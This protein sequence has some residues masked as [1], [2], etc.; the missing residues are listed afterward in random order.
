MPTY[1]KLK[2]CVNNLIRNNLERIQLYY[3]IS[4]QYQC[5]LTNPGLNEMNFTF[6]N[7]LFLLCF[8]LSA[9]RSSAQCVIQPTINFVN[10]SFEGTPGPGLTPSPWTECMPG[11]TPDT[12]PGSWG[13][14]LPPTNGSTYIGLVH[15]PSASWQEGASEQLGSPFLAG[16]SYTFTVDLANSSSTGGGIDPGCAECQIWGGF[17]DCDQNTLLW[18]SGNITPY[19]TWQT[20]TVTFTPTQNFTYCMFQVHGLGCSAQPYILVDNVSAV[21]PSNV[22]ATAAVINNDNCAND[23]TGKGI[24][25]TVGVNPPYTY[26]WSSPFGVDSTLNNVPA[27]SYTV[28]V[29]DAHTCTATASLTITQPLAITLTPDIIQPG[30]SAS[31]GSA[32]MSYAGGTEPFSFIWSNGPTTQ[33]DPNL[34]AGTY[35]ITAT[36][37]NGCKATG[38]VAIV[39]A[40]P[41]TLAANITNATCAASDGSIATTVSGGNAPYTYQWSTAPVQTTPT[42]TGLA[43]NS[44]SLT[45]TDAITCSITAIF[46][47]SQPPPG[48]T[49]SLLVTDIPCFGQGTGGINTNSS[50]GS[51]PYSYVWSNGSTSANVNNLAAGPYQVTINDQTGCGFILDTTITQPDS[52]LFATVTETDIKCN[53][54]NTGTAT[55]VAVGGTRGYTYAWNS[56]PVQTNQVA[57]NLPQNQ[58][59]V[60]VTDANQCTFTATTTV[61]QPAVL[62]ISETH[63]DVLCY[64]AS[65]GS[66]TATANGGVQPYSYHWNTA[67][68]DTG[69]TAPNLPSATYN[70]I[71]TDANLCTATTSSVI[72]QPVSPLAV[73]D[74]LIQPICFGQTPATASATAS[75]GTPGAG[76]SYLWNTSPPQTTQVISNIPAGTYTIVVTDANACTVSDSIVVTTPTALVLNPVVVNVLCFG[77]N[78]GSIATNASG[79]YG[80][81]TYLWSTAPVQTTSTATQLIAGNYNVTVTDMHGCT[82]SAANVVTQ[83]AAPLT[84][85]TDSTNV[86]CFGANTGAA[87]VTA[88]GGTTA[89][90]YAWNT[91]PQQNTAA[92]ISLIAGNYKVTVTDANACTNTAAVI[93]TQPAA[94]LQATPTIHDILC[95]GDNNG[96]INVADNGGTTPYTYAW[97]P[98]SATTQNVSNLAAGNYSTTVTDANSCTLV[99]SN[100]QVTEPAALSLSTAVTNVSCPHHGDGQI[101]TNTNGGLQPYTYNWNNGETTATDTLLNGG[102]YNVVVTDINGCTIGATNILVPELPG[103]SL[104]ATTQ[105]IICFPLKDGAININAS[106]T[107]MPLRYTWSNGEVTPNLS[108]IDTGLYSLTVTDAHNCIADTTLHIGND[109]AFSMSATPDTA[110]IYLG[111]SVNIAITPYGGSFETISWE[112]SEALSCSDCAN[113]IASP[114]TSMLYNVATIDPRGCTAYA[115]VQITVIPRY[116]IFI[117]NAF[118]PNGDGRNDDFEVYGNK[119]AW[120]FF[121]VEIFDRWGEKV[122]ESNDMNFKW[123]GDFKGRATMGVYV[124]AVHVVFLDNHTEKMLKGSVTLIK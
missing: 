73:T 63:V 39:A 7:T 55:V 41:M 96:S 111:Q 59:I 107:F 105:N 83:P 12:Q 99:L 104:Q 92:L 79:S 74:T 68:V 23:S 82:A 42:A 60:T 6:R 100:M 58:Y 117:P 19:D 14:S 86:L 34:F 16:T 118:T 116:D 3:L 124:Y 65:T 27:G 46:A 28:T 90:T 10:P 29:T 91:T 50:G 76:Y 120:K 44:Y 8:V 115:Q 45:V 114:I 24:I 119:E 53:G 9:Y 30:C 123:D 84:L 13:V 38:S 112:P 35:N 33:N 98:V 18:S 89:Y 22:T 62:T 97:A 87:S 109:S 77:N 32:Y 81:Y 66:A 43:A 40:A 54:Q 70:V 4:S 11:Q 69:S 2:N 71:V 51:P 122:Y 64:G 102:T 48:M 1:T 101:N 67:P 61:N 17:G 31:A 25:H 103:V 75:G 26:T 113:P 94:P 95:N 85:T 47:V 78:T 80:N 72:G 121:S 88:N 5:K 20:Y 36:D 37:A 49:A 93:V 110:T 57:N 108:D 15:E 21:V 56:T 52:A 106:S